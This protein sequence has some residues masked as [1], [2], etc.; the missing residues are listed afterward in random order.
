M[1]NPIGLAVFALDILIGL[2]VTGL[3]VYL[4][5]LAKLFGVPPEELLRESAGNSRP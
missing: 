3:F 1:Y 5:A 4:L 2:A